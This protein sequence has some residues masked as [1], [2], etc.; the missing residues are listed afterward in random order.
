MAA[1][2]RPRR[3]RPMSVRAR[4]LPSNFKIFDGPRQKRATAVIRYEN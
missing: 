3:L 4:D 2:L 1:E